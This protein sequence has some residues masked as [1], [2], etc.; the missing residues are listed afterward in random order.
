MD[1]P[2]VSEAV[3]D[4]LRTLITTGQ[5]KPGTRL[6][7]VPLSVELGVSRPPLREAFRTL[8]QEGLA[9]NV[10]RK[11]FRV[12]EL[13][14]KDIREIYEL[15]YGLERTAVELFMPIKDESTLAPLDAAIEQMRSAEAR[16]D[17]LVMVE[18]NWKFHTA[19]IGL[20]NNSRL[21][22]AYEHL[23]SQMQFCMAI[24]LRV[25]ESYF[26]D[27]DDAVIRHEAIVDV[28]KAGNL[29]DVI[30]MILSHGDRS[31]LTLPDA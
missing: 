6:R 21:S 12:I 13:N 7:E 20:A 24:N 4:R 28:I 31:F 2:T 27:P 17:P 15:R 22:T 3:A 23:K 5:L 1:I 26:Q 9:E 19:L 14:P 10:P 29:N 25:R 11:G 18:A 30:R 16:T 8:A